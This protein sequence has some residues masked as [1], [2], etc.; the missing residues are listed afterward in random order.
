MKKNAK[1]RLVA[2]RRRENKHNKK[3]S[4]WLDAFAQPPGV[5][6][7]RQQRTLKRWLMDALGIGPDRSKDQ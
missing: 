3:Y 1:R 4:S 2:K 5:E 7:T 6:E